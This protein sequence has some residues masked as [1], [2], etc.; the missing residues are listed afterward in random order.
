[1]NK[2]KL[3]RLKKAGYRITDYKAFLGLSNAEATLVEMK[4]ALAERVRAVR[5]AQ[6]M[7]QEELARRI[8]S[9]QSRIAKMESATS[10]VSLDLLFKALLTL[11]E[12]SKKLAKTI[13]AAA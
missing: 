6:Q 3:E 1:M 5:T 9:S 4:I 12:D 7:S 10:D 11:G 2:A 8:G 13:A